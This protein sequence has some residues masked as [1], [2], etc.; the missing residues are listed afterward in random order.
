[1]TSKII[2]AVALMFSCH[3]F[4]ATVTDPFSGTNEIKNI[5]VEYYK[6]SHSDQI[7]YRVQIYAQN[8]QYTLP[9]ASMLEAIAIKKEIVESGKLFCTTLEVE[10]KTGGFCKTY[11]IGIDLN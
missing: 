9:A 11:A 6:D 8:G 10:A 2:T 4:A 7:P 1:M 3:S 5:G